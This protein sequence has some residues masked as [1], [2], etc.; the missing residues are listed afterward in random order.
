M[1]GHKELLFNL[2][3]SVIKAGLIGGEVYVAEDVRGNII[4]SIV[5]FGPGQDL[6]LSYASLSTLNVLVTLIN[7][8]AAAGKSS[9]MRASIS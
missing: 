6:L 3:L 1:G 7:I 8:L 5:W 2:E 9:R 4:G